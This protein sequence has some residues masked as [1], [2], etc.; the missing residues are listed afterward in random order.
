MLLCGLN[1][2]WSNNID[3][4]E[5]RKRMNIVCLPISLK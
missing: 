3:F 1:I 4:N 2:M 5:M